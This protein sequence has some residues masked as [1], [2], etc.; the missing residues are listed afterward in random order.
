VP[1]LPGCLEVM[2]RQPFLWTI[3][4][5]EGAGQCLCSTS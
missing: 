3:Q 5:D 2:V 1:I 4:G